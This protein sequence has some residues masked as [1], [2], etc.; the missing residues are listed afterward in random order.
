MKK[1]LLIATGGTIASKPSENGLSPQ[2]GYGE[3]LSYL[4]ELAE[5]CSVDAI[6]LFR[7]DS[8][9]MR[10]CHRLSIAEA[11]RLRY[12]AYDGFVITHGTDT[13]AYTAAVLSYL[14]QQSRKP[15]VLTGSQKSIY[16]RDSDARSNLIAAFHYAVDEGACGVKVVFDHKVILGTRARKLRTKSYSAF[17]SINYPEIAKLRN[18]KVYYYIEEKYSGEPIFYRALDPNIFLLK[19]IPDTDPAL[20]RYAASHYDALV[21]ESFGVGGLPHG[22]GKGKDKDSEFADALSAFLSAGKPIVLTT[23][24]PHEGSDMEV[25][26]VGQTV[27]ERFS[28]IEAYDMTLEAIV[29]KLMWILALTRDPIEIRTR[30]YRPIAHDL[31]FSDEATD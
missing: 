16:E 10:A 15:I 12:D 23:Q 13:M 7:I 27:K 22:K 5:I 4:P 18:G 30:F 28:I 20:I 24:V 6:G 11:I 19:L 9:N 26:E 2:L 3:I 21:I 31:L 14:I 25:Y 8:T 17:A 29:A 1:I